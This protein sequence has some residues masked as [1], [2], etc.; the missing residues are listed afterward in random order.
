MF[1][2]EHGADPHMCFFSQAQ[3]RNIFQVMWDG[4][5]SK[6]LGS[7]AR[8][9]SLVQSRFSVLDADEIRHAIAGQLHNPVQ[10]YKGSQQATK[11]CV[12]DDGIRLP[13]VQ[14]YHHDETMMEVATELLSQGVAGMLTH[15]DDVMTELLLCA[16]LGDFATCNIRLFQSALVHKD[17]IH[18]NLSRV[19][20]VATGMPASS[21]PEGTGQL[22]IVEH[23]L[24]HGAS[25]NGRYSTGLS[26]LHI[27]R[28]PQVTKLLLDWGA[29]P[30]VMSPEGVTP[31]VYAI[32]AP[33]YQGVLDFPEAPGAGVKSKHHRNQMP[34]CLSSEKGRYKI[35]QV[36]AS[37]KALIDSDDK[38]GRTAL[39]HA[40]QLGN[41]RT[42]R[43]FLSLGASID[44]RDNQGMTPLA[45]AVDSGR[46][47]A[48][49]VLLANGAN[50]NAKDGHGNTTLY[51]SIFPRSWEYIEARD[52]STILKLL[53]GH[54]ASTEWVSTE[55][56]QK[57]LDTW[58]SAHLTPET[59][60][61]NTST[62][63]S[64]GSHALATAWRAQRA[65]AE[66][67]GYDGHVS[68]MFSQEFIA[69]HKAALGPGQ[70]LGGST[71]RLT[72]LSIR[73]ARDKRVWSAMQQKRALGNAVSKAAM[74]VEIKAKERDRLRKRWLGLD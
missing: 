61:T 4:L 15:Q 68:W 26:L 66:G 60:N 55:G 17:D 33:Y 2:L 57:S 31:L 11:Y 59:G 67:W 44:L 71:R 58:E 36:L 45:Y 20:R 3:T 72:K 42:V 28:S 35:I 10:G 70:K 27:S 22:A 50:V 38:N 13:Y 23:L 32:V 12:Y 6:R 48:V 34:L 25:P 63:L 30:E 49:E 24:K 37:G 69:A 47:A 40:S 21:M 5:R 14:Y 62:V 53:V 18:F 51:Y 43:L 1:L 9:T 73:A 54:G 7:V 19:L 52:K 29:D 46:R 8:M 65:A 74:R 39:S 41:A 64:N 16:L 56:F